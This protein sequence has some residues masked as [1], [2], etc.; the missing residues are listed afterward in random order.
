MTSVWTGTLISSLLSNTRAVSQDDQIAG[1]DKL[2]YKHFLKQT[3]KFS[4]G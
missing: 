1:P 3:I 4:V 2:T